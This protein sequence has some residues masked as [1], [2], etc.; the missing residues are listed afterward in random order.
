MPLRILRC[1]VPHCNFLGG[2]ES[3]LEIHIG[4]EHGGRPFVC[5]LDNCRAAFLHIAEW[6]EHM[7]QCAPPG[8][9]FDRWY[10]PLGHDI[11][12]RTAGRRDKVKPHLKTHQLDTMVRAK[13]AR[14]SLLSE[15]SVEQVYGLSAMNFVYGM[16]MGGEH[17]QSMALNFTAWLDAPLETYTSNGFQFEGIGHDNASEIYG[18]GGALPSSDPGSNACEPLPEMPAPPTSSWN[19]QVQQL[20]YN[21]PPG[22]YLS[23]LTP[24]T[25]LD[26]TGPLLS[27]HYTGGMMM[28]EAL[29]HA[30]DRYA[31]IMPEEQDQSSL[32][33]GMPS[34]SGPQTGVTSLHP[35]HSLTKDRR[36]R[37]PGEAGSSSSVPK[38]RKVTLPT[39]ALEIP[40]GPN[41]PVTQD[42]QLTSSTVEWPL[43]SQ[44]RTPVTP[45]ATQSL[46]HVDAYSPANTVLSPSNT[47]YATRGSTYSPTVRETPSPH[48]RH[49]TISNPEFPPGPSSGNYQGQGSRKASGT[50]APPP[51]L[52]RES[53][54]HRAY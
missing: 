52:E 4:R 47:A 13:N 21:P 6:L 15:Y 20:G 24:S 18:L 44:P 40:N 3:Q 50:L 42:T 1:P 39:L 51:I 54:N 46:L 23:A 26:T 2:G 48:Q 11:S 34:S 25:S 31:W 8:E 16:G 37:K 5:L 33:S 29:P 17:Y 22:L 53:S 43:T 45:L 38:R 36:K 35:S 7:V 28:S 14:L 32:A 12:I 27:G 19:P 30:S 41:D 49:R 9:D 10:C